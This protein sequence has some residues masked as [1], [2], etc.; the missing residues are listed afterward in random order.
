VI[1]AAIIL[2]LLVIGWRILAE[3]NAFGLARTDPEAAVGWRSNA[4]AALVALSEQH[5]LGAKAQDDY[6][7]AITDAERAIAADPLEAHAIA[8]I[9]LSLNAEGETHQVRPLMLRAATRSRRDLP[10]QGWLFNDA[11]NRG[12]YSGALQYADAL[13][14]VSLDLRNEVISNLKSF[15]GVPEGRAAILARLAQAPPWRSSMLQAITTSNAPPDMIF[16]LLSDLAQTPNPPTNDEI[17]PFLNHLVQ[18]GDYPLAYVMWVQFLPKEQRELV[19]YAFNGDFEFPLSQ[20]PFDWVL[21]GNNGADLEVVDSGDT[22]HGRV[23]HVAFANKRAQPRL[24]AKTMMLPSGPY[25]L[26]ASVRTAELDNERGLVWRV[27][28]LSKDR[29]VIAETPHVKGTIPWQDFSLDFDV[30]TEN[31]TTQLLQLEIDAKSSLDTQISGEAWYDN[32]LVDRRPE[33][34]ATGK[35]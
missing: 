15:I 14:R 1:S 30:P 11:L 16:A 10:V 22:T 9:A 20:Q 24:A 31:C 12:D 28:C 8:L 27:Y 35:S 29:Q 19:R 13:L 26:S 18:Q 2:L 7:T 23:L 32:F 33:T 5:L 3:I 25:K 21:P 4:S 17:R 34:A 6:A